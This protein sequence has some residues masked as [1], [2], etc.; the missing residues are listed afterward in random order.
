MGERI[1]IRVTFPCRLVS[2]ANT[3]EHWTRRARRARQQRVDAKIRML[4]TGAHV[5][6]GHVVVVNLTRIAPRP[7]DGDNLQRAFKA[8]RDGVADWLERDDGAATITWHYAQER[9]GT[10]AHE[11]RITV[12]DRGPEEPAAE[13]WPPSPLEDLQTAIAWV[14]AHLLSDDARRGGYP[15]VRA[16]DCKALRTIIRHARGGAA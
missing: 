3:R 4:S 10:R 8:V 9:G 12:I 5:P 15:M 7:L 1:V 13:A 6:D 2:E 16:R 11:V 14:E